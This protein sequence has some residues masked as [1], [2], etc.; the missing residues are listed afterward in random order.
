MM[1][2]T[3][4]KQDKSMGMKVRRKVDIFRTVRGSINVSWI[5]QI[6]RHH[7]LCL[8]TSLHFNQ[9]PLHIFVALCNLSVALF[10]DLILIIID[11]RCL[12]WPCS[13]TIVILT[14]RRKETSL[15]FSGV[16]YVKKYWI[17]HNNS[18][19]T[20]RKRKCASL[21]LSWSSKWHRCRGLHYQQ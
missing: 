17:Q 21:N 16:T 19:N 5:S 1:R 11:L 12:V 6:K 13:Y 4:E 18:T 9:W 2:I 3:R 20:R 10:K 7:H 8:N 14:C 15:V